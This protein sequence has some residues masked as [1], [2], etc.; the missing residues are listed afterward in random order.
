MHIPFMVDLPG[1][2]DGRKSN[3]CRLLFLLAINKGRVP[4]RLESIHTV[5]H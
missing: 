1:L 2:E 3:G 5:Y 4:K